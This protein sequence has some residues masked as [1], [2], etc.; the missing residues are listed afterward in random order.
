MDS[1]K[2]KKTLGP[3]TADDEKASLSHT[4]GHSHSESLSDL[5]TAD[6]KQSVY[7]CHIVRDVM[8]MNK[9]GSQLLPSTACGGQ[10]VDL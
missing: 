5:H 4:E 10:E 2:K 3:L 9:A 1:G 6:K 7:H 8:E